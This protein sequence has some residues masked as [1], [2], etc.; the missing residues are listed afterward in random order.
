MVSWNCIGA[1]HIERAVQ[2]VVGALEVAE[3][4]A[5]L[6]ERG[7]RHGE[8]VALAELFVQGHAALGQRERLLVAVANQRD[9]GLV[10]ADHRQHIVGLQQRGQALG[11]AQRGVASS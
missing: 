6:A 10:A 1:A 5:D 4:H 8:P 9:V 3:A 7:E 2:H 11:L